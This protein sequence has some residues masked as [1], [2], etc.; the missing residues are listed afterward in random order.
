MP[1]QRGKTPDNWWSDV[2]QA[3]TEQATS[4]DKLVRRFR[5]WRI[6][7]IA[8]LIFA[9]LVT[10]SG[11]A[12]IA[13][14]SDATPGD[15]AS[16]FTSAPGQ[17]EATLAVTAWIAG[18]NSPLPGGH[19]L[20]WVG[21][22]TTPWPD[23]ADR[24]G[25]ETP[26]YDLWVHTFTVSNASGTIIYTASVQVASSESL[27]VRVIGNP[28]LIPGA[29]PSSDLPTTVAWPGWGTS[30]AAQSLTDA[31]TQWVKAYTSGDAT[32]LRLAVGDPDDSHAYMPLTGI[33]DVQ[34]SVGAAATPAATNP[35]L[36]TDVAL[37]RV[38][39]AFLRSGSFNDDQQSERAVSTFDL[40]LLV[41]DASTGAP[42]VVAWSGPGYGVLLTPYVNAVAADRVKGQPDTEPTSTPEVP[43]SP[44]PTAPQSP[45]PTATNS[46][47]EGMD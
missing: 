36:G 29:P 40:D 6:V 2:E 39:V 25:E 38:T 18:D 8:T 43:A 46:T 12:L 14:R 24:I 47:G 9:P 3:P 44:T 27:G 11:A 7:I 10:L 5:V 28:S 26:D 1:K 23:S 35:N 34:V 22:T 16:Q 37:V 21:A 41:A 17:S 32:A 13:Q 42:R 20:T 4:T 15:V 30:Q 19:V 45:T 31:V 33:T